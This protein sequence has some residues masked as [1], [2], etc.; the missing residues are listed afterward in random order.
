MLP[1]ES[2]ARKFC[3]ECRAMR[4]ARGVGNVFRF[5]HFA[6][7]EIDRRRIVRGPMHHEQALLRVGADDRSQMV[8]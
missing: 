2:A 6:E 1:A 3:A 8:H 4:D 5:L 7:P